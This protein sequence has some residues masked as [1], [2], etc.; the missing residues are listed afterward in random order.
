MAEARSPAEWAA[1]YQARLEFLKEQVQL[2]LPMDDPEGRQTV[3][4]FA[5]AWKQERRTDE[6]PW[7]LDELSQRMEQLTQGRAVSERQQDQGM[8]Y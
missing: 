2:G 5:Q 1:Y 6:K 8:D 3:L 7:T 4:D